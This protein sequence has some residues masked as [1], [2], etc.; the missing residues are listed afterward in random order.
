ME[1]GMDEIP[2]SDPGESES[3]DDLGSLTQLTSHNQDGDALER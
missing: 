3:I 1:R 2:E